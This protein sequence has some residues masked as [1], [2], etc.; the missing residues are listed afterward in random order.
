VG[1]NISEE[2]KYGQTINTGVC[3]ENIS[4]VRTAIGTLKL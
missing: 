2:C 1:K 3:E 4:H